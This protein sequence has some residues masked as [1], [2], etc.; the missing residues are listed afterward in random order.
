MPP[1]EAMAKLEGCKGVK[2]SK[3]T[4]PSG[5]ES[6]SGVGPVLVWQQPQRFLDFALLQGTSPGQSLLL[7]LEPMR[8][9]TYKQSGSEWQ[10]FHTA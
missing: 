8:L 4:D 6:P 9:V 5:D 7:V 10:L 1:G 3:M 2:W